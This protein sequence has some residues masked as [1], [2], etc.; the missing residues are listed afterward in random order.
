MIARLCGGMA[1]DAH[2]RLGEI[3][4]VMSRAYE[5]FE[6]LREGKC[7]ALDALIADRE[8]ESLFLDFKRASE[9]GAPPKLEQDVNENLSK[10]ISGFANSSGGVVIW[11]V[12]CQL[13][14]AKGDELAKKHP[15]VN[16]SGFNTKIQAAISRTTLPAHPGVQVL[17]FDEPAKSPAGYVAVYIPQSIV[18]PIRSL[19]SNHYHVRTGSAFGYVPHDVLA[20]MFGRRPQ[21]NPDVNVISHPARLDHQP[22]HLVLSIGLV[23]VNLGSVVGERPYLSGFF[24]DLPPGF[25]TVSAADAKHYS[26]RR[27]Q[28]PNFSVV[29]SAGFLLVPGATEHMCDVVIS[30]PVSD[31]RAINIE[32]T[33]GVLGAPPKRFTLAASADDVRAAITWATSGP[34]P[35]TETLKLLRGS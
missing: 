23:A 11:G 9:D 20:G 27:G 14:K 18:G 34:F 29:S 21:P 16:A 7:L 17:S 8:P 6:R 3:V 32:C 19:K 25:L 13:D 2:A 30:I 28:I 33:L 12:D 5:L 31:P 35:S 24:G 15:L 22:G 4:A 26:V 1:G 10:A